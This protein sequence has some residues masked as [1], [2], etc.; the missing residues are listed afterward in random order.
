MAKGFKHGSGGDPKKV[1]ILDDAFPQDVTVEAAGTSVTFEVVI[2]ED[3]KPVGYTYQWYYDNSLVEGATGSTYTR[4]AEFGSH[5]VHCVVGNP[6]GF[7]TTRTATVTAERLYLYN[8]GNQCADITGGWKNING[9]EYHGYNTMGAYYDNG[10][11]FTLRVTSSASHIARITNNKID[12][13]DVNKISV[14][15]L[16]CNGG[17]LT[18]STANTA[19]S[20]NVA[21]LPAECKIDRAGTASLDV[22]SITGEY[23]VAIRT[24]NGA[25]DGTNR[26][27]TVS[28]IYLE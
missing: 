11:S 15:A 2:A 23:Y 9:F 12:F 25:G 19:L 22:S 16:E 24:S 5:S 21:S 8:S 26:A 17:Y 27:I 20:S 7:A 3:G 18:L 10:D 14:V 28:Q 1:P 6:V 13:T 4:T